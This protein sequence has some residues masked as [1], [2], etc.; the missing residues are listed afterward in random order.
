MPVFAPRAKANRRWLGAW[1]R[2]PS[3]QASRDWAATNLEVWEATAALWGRRREARTTAEDAVT[4]D[5][6]LAGGGPNPAF[7]TLPPVAL[8]HWVVVNQRQ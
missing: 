3:G 5:C 6:G 1:M 2:M 8:N 4:I 7:K